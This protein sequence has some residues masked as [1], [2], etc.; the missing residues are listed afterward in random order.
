MNIV[1]L[2]KMNRKTEKNPTG[3]GLGKSEGRIR[4]EK[5]DLIKLMKNYQMKEIS[6]MYG[7]SITLV[8]IVLTNQL[9]E[10]SIGFEDIIDEFSALDYFHSKGAWM[11]SEERKSLNHYKNGK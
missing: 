11:D 9:I 5:A 1:D 6:K 10:R 7:V 8:S 4:L 2:N 3:V